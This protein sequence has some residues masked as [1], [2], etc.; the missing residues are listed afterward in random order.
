MVGGD[1][2]AIR[3]TGEEVK[4]S[5]VDL[6]CLDTTLDRVSVPPHRD[7]RFG[8]LP[9]TGRVIVCLRSILKSRY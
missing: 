9:F 6:I 3:K 2:D 8:S 5:K 1:N 4:V 7:L